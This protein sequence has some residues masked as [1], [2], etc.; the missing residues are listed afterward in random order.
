MSHTVRFVH[1]GEECSTEEGQTILD[2]ATANNIL[3]VRGCHNGVCDLCRCT[4]IEGLHN[5]LNKRTGKPFRAPDRVLAC[6]AEVRGDVI[7]H[8][9]SKPVSPGNQ[10]GQQSEREAHSSVQN[11]QHLEEFPNQ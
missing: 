9:K 7:V 2:A 11:A 1:T 3:L 10:Q 5:V 8:P 4:V 6:L